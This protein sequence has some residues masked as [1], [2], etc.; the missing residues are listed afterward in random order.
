MNDSEMLKA[1]IDNMKDYVAF[2]DLKGRL[3]KWNENSPLATPLMKRNNKIGHKISDDFSGDWVNKIQENYDKV[4]QSGKTI[5][6]DEHSILEGK[7]YYFH[8]IRFPVFD[9]DGNVIGIGSITTP[10]S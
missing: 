8:A 6:F 10:A 5:E 3:L 4:M 7:D 2:R 1:L 9:S